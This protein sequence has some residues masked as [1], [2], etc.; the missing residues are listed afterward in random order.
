MKSLNTDREQA[1]DVRQLEVEDAIAR[2]DKIKKATGREVP[3]EIFAGMQP[4]SKSV[5]AMAKAPEKEEDEN[6]K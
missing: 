3:W 4:A 1:M 6:A 2:A 5:V